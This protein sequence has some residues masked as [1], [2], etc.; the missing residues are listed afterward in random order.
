MGG[1]NLND[2]ETIY[3]TNTDGNKELKLIS[4]IEIDRKIIPAKFLHEYIKDEFISVPPK[5]RSPET[6]N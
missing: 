1:V 4:D 6:A 3:L 2:A 5:P